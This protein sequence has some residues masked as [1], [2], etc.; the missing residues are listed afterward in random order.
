[1]ERNNPK[2]ISF[3]SPFIE[4]NEVCVVDL[5]VA[6]ILRGIKT[7]KDFKKVKENFSYFNQLTTS[8]EKV[9][10]L[11]FQTARKGFWP[12]LTDLYIAQ[13]VFENHKVLITMD[14]DF[15]NIGNVISLQYYLLTK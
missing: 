13:A 7:V 1:M 3:I 10:E 5:I 8:W 12:P 15:Q 2:I 11:A 4:K 6:E 9:A 14:K